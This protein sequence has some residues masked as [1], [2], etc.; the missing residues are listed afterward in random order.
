LA[1][2]VSGF[3]LDRDNEPLRRML[4]RALTQGWGAPVQFSPTAIA[5]IRHSP[6]RPLIDRAAEAW[7]ARLSAAEL[8]QQEL[9]ALRDP[10]L[11]ALMQSTAVHDPA[12]EK[13]LAACRFALL[14]IAEAAPPDEID[15]A[16]LSSVCALARQCFIN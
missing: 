10:L 4:T 2:L 15:E 1:R 16:L 6:M 7:P 9:A 11:Q 14:E 12:L 5:L 8:G 13:F 3:L